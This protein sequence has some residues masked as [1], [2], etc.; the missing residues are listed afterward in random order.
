MPSDGAETQGKSEPV[1]YRA[2]SGRHAESLPPW[3]EDREYIGAD[4][5]PAWIKH[6]YNLTIW[7]G[8]V[9]EWIHKGLVI[10]GQRFY[11]PGRRLL[12]RRRTYVRIEDLKTW[13]RA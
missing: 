2:V 10:D 5:V 1:N 6:Y 4:E 13:M 7:Q 9:M 11:L 3:H 8:T 12:G